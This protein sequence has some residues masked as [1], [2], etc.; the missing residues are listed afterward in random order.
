[1]KLG[2]DEDTVTEALESAREAEFAGHRAEMLDRLDQAVENGDIAADRAAE[3]RERLN[4]D[5]G[6]EMHGGPRPGPRRPRPRRPGVWG[7]PGLRVIQR[8][9]PPNPSSGSSS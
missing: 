7:F 3:M 8:V 2:L 9:A 5:D 1:M 6:A 4:S